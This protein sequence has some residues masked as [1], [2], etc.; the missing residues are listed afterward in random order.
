MIR[1]LTDFFA[2]G[3]FR[4]RP[5]DVHNRI[6]R[7]ALRQ[8]KLVYYT[9]RGMIDH[10]TM[11]RSAS[12]TFYTLMSIVPVAALVFAV[13]KGFGMSE[14]LTSELH[15]ALPQFPE[16]I[17]Y[18]VGFANN[19]LE[20]TRGGLLATF[21]VV[22][23]FWAVMKVFGSVEAAFNNI[24]EVKRSRG[25]ARQFSDYIAV[26]VVVPVL[27]IS[28]SGAVLYLRQWLGI[29]D[30]VGYHIWSNVVSVA[31]IWAMFTFLYIVLPNTKVR[32]SSAFTAAVVAGTAF[33]AFQRIY[34]YVQSSMSSYN[35]IY[36]S[37]AAL[38]LFLIWLQSSWQIV[39]FGGELAFAYQNEAKFEQERDSM[40]IS[41]DNRRKVTLAA[42]L[43][44]VR[45]FVSSRGAVSSEEISRQLNLPVRIVRDVVF[46]LERAGLLLSVKRGENDRQ[47]Y[48]TPAKDV[49]K[50]TLYDVIV[51]VESCGDGNVDMLDSEE[52][53]AVGRLLDSIR[54]SA[55]DSPLNELLVNIG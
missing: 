7:W 42:M 2:E 33:V 11:M 49:H 13:L 52:M 44:I 50:L 15:K 29:G 34:V 24:W 46:D 19:A 54:A 30:T 6:G 20:R 28:S 38:P 45:S 31:L 37:F 3:I 17:D 26:V 1:R 47:L 40:H 23:L 14:P 25:L 21:G 39:L 18:I 53:R 22:M 55:Y 27:W 10:D 4:L 5:S 8:Y 12:L 43:T 41:L 35:A 32:F 36:G 16:F 9:V 51:S 48:Y